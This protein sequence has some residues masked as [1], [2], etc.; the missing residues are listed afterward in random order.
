MV[1]HLG[2]ALASTTYFGAAGF[3]APFLFGD[4]GVEFFFVLSGFIVT[5]V[6]FQD[7][8]KPP[9]LIP[10]LRK[11]L[12]RI[13][14]TYWI[15]F[16]SVYLFAYASPL[17][18][19]SLPLDL[20]TIAKSL[21]LVPQNP[22]LAG[23]TGAPVLIVAWSLQYEIL[24]YAV[25]AAL[26]LNRS[27]GIILTGLLLF[28]FGSCELQACT[29]PRSFLAS[30]LLLLFG[31]GA[32]VAF[33]CRS[34]LA[35]KQPLLLSGIGAAAFLA[36][37]LI[38]IVINKATLPIDRRLVYGAFSAVLILGLV[39]AEIDGHFR[40]TPA[41]LTLLGDA[42]YALYLIHFPLISIL[43][44]AFISLGMSGALGAA[45]AYPIILAACILAA[46][47]FHLLVEK[48]MLQAIGRRGPKPA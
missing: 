38:E 3:A 7:I 29:F 46:V 5:W 48:P 23:G 4:S 8:G 42:S 12:L 20:I 10:Y 14:P 47:G 36:T 35:L 17:T 45:I 37:G 43:C 31:M 2:G 40:G 34:S 30:N 26:V 9:R 1:F 28:N 44:K 32:V 24:F 33:A 39:R 6:H 16:G 11:R 15:V 21:A 27:L 25:I 22:A 41:W 13:Y 19:S 18:R